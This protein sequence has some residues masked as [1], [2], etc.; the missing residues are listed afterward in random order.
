M[1]TVGSTLL[2]PPLRSGK[3]LALSFAAHGTINPHEGL[4]DSGLKLCISQSISAS[5]IG[6]S[7][8]RLAYESLRERDSAVG[9]SRRR[10][11]TVLGLNH[12]LVFQLAKHL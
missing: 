4:I 5:A 9:G 8:S 1:S 6:T 12:R 7:R 2:V 3:I 11:S 10:S